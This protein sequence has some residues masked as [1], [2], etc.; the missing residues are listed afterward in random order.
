MPDSDFESERR[1]DRLS[2]EPAVCKPQGQ[3]HSAHPSSGIPA[4][5]AREGRGAAPQPSSARNAPGVI[6]ARSCAPASW[7]TRSTRVE[8]VA[9]WVRSALRWRVSSRPTRTPASNAIAIALTVSCPVPIPPPHQLV[10]GGR[11]ATIA[12]MS[13]RST[14]APATLPKNRLKEYGAR[15]PLAR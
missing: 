8:L 11:A 13:R 7:V 12:A 4:V 2:G 3:R 6:T 1:S 9:D 14:W 10:S 5:R 15:A